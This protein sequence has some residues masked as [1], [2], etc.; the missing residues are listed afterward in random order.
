MMSARGPGPARPRFPARLALV[1]GAALV[2]ASAVAYRSRR[3]AALK[4]SLASSSEVV[5][6]IAA[7]LERGMATSREDALFLASLDASRSALQSPS[8]RP[9]LERVFSSF[10]RER[11]AMLQAR[12]LDLDGR[13]VVRVD[14]AD[15]RITAATEL[16]DKSDRYYV[17]AARQLPIGIA[18]VSRIDLNVEHEHVELPP[19]PVVRFAAV[20]AEGA[21]PAGLVVINQDA[22]PL[23]DALRQWSARASGELVLIDG[24]GAYLSHPDPGRLFGSPTMLDNGQGLGRD[25]P[26]LARWALNPGEATW[27]SGDTISARADLEGVAGS[28]RVLVVLGVDQAMAAAAPELL[29]LIGWLVV[30]AAAAA[31]CVIT[32]WRRALARFDRAFALSRT[33]AETL[34]EAAAVLAHEVRNP[35]AA[36]V[37][38]VAQLRAERNVTPLDADSVRLMDI[39]LSESARLERTLDDFLG[40]ARPAPVRHQRVDLREVADDIVALAKS[41]P[42]FADQVKLEVEGPSLLVLADPDQLR[43]VLWNLVLNAGAA[44]RKTG[45]PAVRVRV[46]TGSEGGGETALI[47]VVDSGP[48]PPT[49]GADRRSPA[50]GGLGLIIAAGIVAQHGGQLE[51]KDTGSGTRAV[52]TLPINLQEHRR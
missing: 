46:S 27:M 35:L 16:Q 12:L 15:G 21:S 41:D 17:R 3:D 26:E 52:V 32:V 34:A 51:L 23:L 36:I 20:V 29:S 4:Q 5:R 14:R 1:L 7:D 43:Q 48:G 49:S 8:A 47:E 28:P 31:L 18:F 13:E 6:V 10:L 44:N 37:S 19:V 30:A 45:R 11:S 25:R 42:L 39:V 50:R 33:R 22:R 24:D 2:V 9:A 38:S 40:L